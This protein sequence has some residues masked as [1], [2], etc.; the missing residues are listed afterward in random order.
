V[1]SALNETR[2]FSID[3]ETTGLFPRDSRILL[4]QIGIKPDQWFVIDAT[5]V[6]LEPIL[7]FLD[8][9]AW[10]KIIQESKFERAFFLTKYGIPINNVFDTKLAE[11]VLLP[12]GFRNGLDD[13]AEKYTDIRLDKK[14][15]KSFYERRKFQLTE[16]QIDYAAK[17]VEVLWPIMEAQQV[18]LEEKGLTHIADLEFEVAQVVASM[19]EEG[20][21]IDQAKWRGLMSDYEERR[22]ASRLKMLDLLY[23]SGENE[24]QL[25]FFSR[26]GINIS[27]PAQLKK[28][29]N[30]IGIDV[31]KTNEREISQI[32][33]PAAREL[34]EY[35]GLD[36]INTSYGR[37]FLDKIHPFTGRIHAD[38]QQLG[39]ETGRFSCKE[40]N[41]QQVPKEFR[42]CVTLDDYV[43]VGADYSQIELRIIAELSG[44][45]NMSMA[46]EK[47]LDLHR[48]TAS[49]MFGIPFDEVDDH[50]RFIAKS[51]NFGIAYG[52]GP[53]K[54]K[55]TV[56]TQALKNG[57]SQVSFEEA[58]SMLQ[59]YKST[60]KD[61]NR[62]LTNASNKAFISLESE[63]MYGRKRFYNRPDQNKLDEK[64]YD[65]QVGGL[66]RQGANSPIQGTNADIT[67]LAM[68][69]VHENLADGGYNAK[70]ILQVHDEIVVLAHK[71]QAE[72]V[73]EVIVSSMIESAEKVLKKVP[74]KADAY[75]N[76]Y[77]KK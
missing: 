42:E 22:E 53:N 21:P 19:Q 25:G 55:E 71:R 18:A 43:I 51:I 10:L 32:D 74:V 40:P 4:C 29:L 26:G 56:N 72:A 1:V 60:Y 41:M 44:D 12:D 46:F 27:S 69:N 38:W 61:V 76:D 36:K 5:K 62:W 67:K 45:R 65:K 34:L 8:D 47:N 35:R 15:R 23:E 7:P 14:V 30:K 3:L 24:E 33:H 9:H 6:A 48:S 68:L 54:L 75:I 49:L 31:E 50:Q 37:S 2:A 28:A 39:T 57:K 13:L 64:E 70:I 66:K 77:W 73:K 20:T 16:E 63:T 58:L 59:K 52:M 17:D 11:K